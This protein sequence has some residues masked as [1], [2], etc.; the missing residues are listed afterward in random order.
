MK[1]KIELL[2]REELELIHTQTLHLLQTKGVKYDSKIALNYL[3]DAGQEVDYDNL[4]AKISPDL[5]EKCLESAPKLGEVTLYGRDDRHEIIFDGGRTYY[6]NEYGGRDVLDFEDYETH[7]YRDPTIDDVKRSVT[8]ADALDIVHIIWPGCFPTDCP[9][10][11]LDLYNQQICFTNSSKHL[12]DQARDLR[13]VPYKLEILDAVL[14]D[15]RKM[16]EKPAVSLIFDTV[17]PLRW[18]K[19]MI[20]ATIEM[21]KNWVPSFVHSRPQP[22][23]TSPVTPAGTLLQGNAEVLSGI[24]L[25]QLV[26]P[27]IP[28]A[29]SVTGTCVDMRSG[30]AV[31]GQPLER[32]LQSAG[33]ELAHF[34]NLPAWAWNTSYL[35]QPEYASGLGN[36]NTDLTLF[37]ERYI[38]DAERFAMV[39]RIHEGFKVNEESLMRLDIERVAYDGTF[40]KEMS[41]RNHWTEEYFVTTLGEEGLYDLEG[42][43]TEGSCSSKEMLQAA[44]ERVEHILATHQVNPPLSSDVIKEMETIIKRAQKELVG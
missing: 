17:S 18:E 30:I 6:N 2:S 38:I 20:E 11:L 29:H 36:Y 32:L 44:H 33:V 40:L 25:L 5:V 28:V 37:L 23:V 41:T 26:Q 31:G 13:L 14:G 8:L 43:M 15:R 27:G 12:Q 3:E 42:G 24:V 19:D 35:V 22:G 39:D 4:T 1:P 16:K 21:T 9:P 10:V 34:Y 7:K